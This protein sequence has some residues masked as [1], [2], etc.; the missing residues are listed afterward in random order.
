MISGHQGVP[1]MDLAQAPATEQPDLAAK[2]VFMTGGAFSP[3]A[4]VARNAERT[5]D[6]PFNIIA[7]TLRRL[8]R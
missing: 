4:F 7:E 2:M 8:Q 3:R 5:V 1:G 6:K